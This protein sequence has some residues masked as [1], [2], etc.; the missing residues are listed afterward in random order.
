MALVTA[1]PPSWVTLFTTLFLP[2]VLIVAGVVL[3][4]SKPG[5]GYVLAATYLW[6]FAIYVWATL[7]HLF[8]PLSSPVLITLQHAI[9]WGLIAG[10]VFY[11]LL[12][13]LS[14]AVARA[15]GKYNKSLEKGTGVA[16]A[17]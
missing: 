8:G 12:A 10:V 3:A 9:A 17:S 11:G 7:V 13:M 5:T 15:G 2:F 14:A 4:F 1:F 16:G 6:L